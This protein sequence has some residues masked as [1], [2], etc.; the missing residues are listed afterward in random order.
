[1]AH[2]PR[3]DCRRGDR[4]ARVRVPGIGRSRQA[5]AVYRLSRL[6][7]RGSRPVAGEPGNHRAWRKGAP[8]RADRCSLNITRP[9]RAGFVTVPGRSP[10]QDGAHRRVEKGGFSMLRC[11]VYVMRSHNALSACFGTVITCLLCCYAR[12]RENNLL[13]LLRALFSHALRVM[14]GGAFGRSLSFY[15]GT[16]PR[17]PFSPYVSVPYRVML[18]YN[19]TITA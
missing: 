15:P 7:R 13:L 12:E 8:V 18:T 6:R 2:I 9:A 14:R 1:M 10:S 3:P 17:T 19:I 4:R 11:Y 16:P 5:P